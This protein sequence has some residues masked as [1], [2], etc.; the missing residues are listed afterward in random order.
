MTGRNINAVRQ[1]RASRFA[2]R[3]VVSA[4][5]YRSTLVVE[6]YILQARIFFISHCALILARYFDH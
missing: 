1:P 3:L 2:L 4:H 5:R 6:R